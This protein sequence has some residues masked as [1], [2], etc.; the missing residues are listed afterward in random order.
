[1][2]HSVSVVNSYGMKLA[3]GG[4]NVAL[5]HGDSLDKTV[6][7]ICTVVCN[8]SVR[9][10][11]SGLGGAGTYGHNVISQTSGPLQSYDSQVSPS[12]PLYSA[13]QKKSTHF[14]ASLY[15]GPNFS[16]SANTQSVMVGIHLA[17]KQS[18]IPCTSSIL[19]WIEKLIKLVST[20]IR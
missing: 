11:R 10:S 12:P 15:F 18:I 19:F 9:N 8:E 4:N 5:V 3:Y 17:I 14:N 13:F 16:N 7:R 1:M 20:K 6:V 2:N